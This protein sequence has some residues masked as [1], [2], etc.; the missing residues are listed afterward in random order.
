[1]RFKVWICPTCKGRYRKS[2]DAFK[3]VKKHQPLVEE[4]WECHKCGFGIRID[5]RTENSYDAEVRK[6]NEINCLGITKY[7]LWKGKEAHE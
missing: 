6:H 3:C 4:W 2:T 1:M 5:N 7:E